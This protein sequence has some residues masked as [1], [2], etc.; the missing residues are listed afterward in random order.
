MSGGHL[1]PALTLGVYVERSKWV[2]YGGWALA[3]IIFQMIG[4]FG[5]IG[6][7]WMLRAQVHS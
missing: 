4:A 1:N 3:I 2:S 6:L 5:G 7:G